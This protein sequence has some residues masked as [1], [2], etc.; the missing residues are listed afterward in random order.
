MLMLP[1]EYKRVLACLAAFWTGIGGLSAQMAAQRPVYRAMPA[2]EC[3]VRDGIGNVMAKIGA[4]RPIRIAYLGGS[5]TEMDGWRR[6]SREW[7]QEQYPACMFSE[8]HAAIG[9]TGSSLGVYRV[10]E[11]VLKYDPDLIFVEFA[12]N[13]ASASAWSIWKNFEG[14]VRQVWKHNPRID[15][16][17]VYTVNAAMV[18]DYQSGRC[19]QSASAME[20]VADHFGIPSVNFGLR[21]AADAAAG[22]LVMNGGYSATAVPAEDFDNEERLADIYAQNG[23]RLFSKDGVH[24]ILRAHRCYYL[25]TLADS[26]PKLADRP[27]AD[28]AQKLAVPFY[29]TVLEDAKEVFPDRG[30]VSGSWMKE[31]EGWER[32]FGASPWFTQTPGDKLHFAFR[33]SVCKI[34]SIFGNDCGQL[35]VTVDGVRRQAP[36]PLFDKDST[37]YRANETTVFSG[38]DGVHEVE[39]ELDSAQPD[40]SAVGSDA[41]NNPA[42]YDG[43]RWYLGGILLLGDMEGAAVVNP[44]DGSV[45]HL[46]VPSA[47]SAYAPA[48]AADERGRPLRFGASARFVP[49]EASGTVRDDWNVGVAVSFDKDVPDGAVGIFTCTGAAGD[50][51]Q[52]VETA[53]GWSVG[54][55]RRL[56]NVS[57]SD[58]AAF[59][60]DTGV[61]VGIKCLTE[62]AIGTRVTIELRLYEKAQGVE[63]GRYATLSRVTQTVEDRPKTEWFDARIAT[64]SAWPQ[65]ASQA[66][67]GRWSSAE[68]L[69]DAAEVLSPGVLD[70]DARMPLTFSADVV[71]E[72]NERTAAV[73][74]SSEQVLVAYA[75]DELPTVESDWKGAVIIVESGETRTYCGLV[76]GA[77]AP[78]DG[79]EP[80]AEKQPVALTMTFRGVGSARTVTYMINGVTCSSGGVTALPVSATGAVSSVDYV[81]RGALKLLSGTTDPVRKGICIVVR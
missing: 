74:V 22:T 62:S 45:E 61:S 44:A 35:L 32:Q 21:V 37:Y 27:T 65:D 52:A 8:T 77:W 9:G 79:M 30:L 34:F 38:E 15:I 26:W 7:L 5:I 67:F 39:I 66:H 73:S 75:P 63:A 20:M 59:A 14:I 60:E 47:G 23:K 48:L 71:Q 42:K 13:D 50:G 1:R 53:G 19:P 41:I 57:W 31:R 6:L 55:I 70:V 33:G 36:L 10:G 69:R 72:P 28:H 17:F 11:H 51:W 24:P 29:D 56:T 80:P 40:R 49:G 18:P 78:L 3:Q 81:G 64:Y 76:G 12:V 58:F 16:V 46:S 54:S 25:A 4:D 2:V 43:T 68:S